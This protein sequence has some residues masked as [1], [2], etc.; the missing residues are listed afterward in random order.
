MAFGESL[1]AS[2][3]IRKKL[4]TWLDNPPD[5]FDVKA[6]YET[7]GRQRSRVH[8]KKSDI[9]AIEDKIKASADKP[10]SNE[11]K[12]Q[13]VNDTRDLKDELAVLESDLE[14]YEAYVK[15]LEYVKSMYASASYQS[16]IL[17]E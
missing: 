5:Y 9:V 14:E 8:R 1:S 16:K 13:I 6:A 11:T 3:V 4:S 2:D 7:L 12:L 17:Y 10:R 15:F